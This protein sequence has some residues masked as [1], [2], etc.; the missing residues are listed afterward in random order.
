M[1]TESLDKII[2]KRKIKQDIKTLF[3]RQDNY[4]VEQINLEKQDEKQEEQTWA[5]LRFQLIIL[6]KFYFQNKDNHILLK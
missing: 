6:K 5:R 2:V 4:N 1:A 3:R